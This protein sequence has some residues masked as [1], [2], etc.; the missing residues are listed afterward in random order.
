MCSG[1]LHPSLTLSDVGLVACEHSSVLRTADKR[2]ADK[3]SST[4]MSGGSWQSHQDA[5]SSMLLA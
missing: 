2:T 4:E 3:V 5:L 1:N